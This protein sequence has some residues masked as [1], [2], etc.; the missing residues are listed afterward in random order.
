M[1]ANVDDT[2]NKGFW[3]NSDTR[4][5]IVNMLSAH[6]FSFATPYELFQIFVYKSMEAIQPQKVQSWYTLEFQ[7]LNEKMTTKCG[8]DFTKKG[9]NDLALVSSP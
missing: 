4:S 8:I 1:S 9:V 7:L 5:V 3:L 6:R 2:K